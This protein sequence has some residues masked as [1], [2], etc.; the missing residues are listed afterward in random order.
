QPLTVGAL[1]PQGGQADDPDRLRLGHPPGPFQPLADGFAVHVLHNQIGPTLGNPL[2]EGADDVGVVE[3]TRRDVFLFEALQVGDVGGHLSGQQFYG[4]YFS[5]VPMP[6]FVDGAHTAI[7]DLFH[8]VIISDGL[9]SR[10][11]G[12]RRHLQDLLH[13]TF[14]RFDRRSPEVRC[15][16]VSHRGAGFPTCPAVGTVFPWPWPK[17][18]SFGR[19]ASLVV[20]VG[21]NG[22]KCLPNLEKG[23]GSK[24][25]DTSVAAR[26]QRAGGHREFPLLPRPYTFIPKRTANPGAP[27]HLTSFR[28]WQARRATES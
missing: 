6:A 1:E 25:G 4:N 14:S 22:L 24:T 27:S 19:A 7:G 26:W 21:C 23:P 5:G 3:R 8:Q 28:E 12:F 2:F 18:V 15:D 17:S 16:A 9:Q 10:R 11:E 13:R 20:I